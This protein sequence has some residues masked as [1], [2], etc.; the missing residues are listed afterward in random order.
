MKRKLPAFKLKKNEFVIKPISVELS[1]AI[2]KWQKELQNNEII[3]NGLRAR[4]ISFGY[5]SKHLAKR[6]SI[7]SI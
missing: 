3:K 2:V 1:K 6:I 5:A 7:R 4:H